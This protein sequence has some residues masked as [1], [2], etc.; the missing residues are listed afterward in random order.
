M[1]A[2]MRSGLGL[3]SAGGNW[4]SPTAYRFALRRSEPI[5]PIGEQKKVRPVAAVRESLNGSATP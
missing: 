4:C 5:Q 3:I 1:D 2:A